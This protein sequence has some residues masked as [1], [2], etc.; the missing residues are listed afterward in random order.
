MANIA[1]VFPAFA[2][3]GAENVA[4]T[5]CDVLRSQYG[6]SI[7]IWAS[8]M[9]PG[10]KEALTARGYQ[11]E[12]FAEQFKARIHH[13]KTSRH[14]AELVCRHSIDV[15]IISVNAVG[16]ADELRR[17]ISPRCKIIFHLHGAPMWELQDALT[18]R[19]VPAGKP[20]K[21]LAAGLKYA[22]A[23]LKEGLF[24]TYSRRYLR[25]YRDMYDISDSYWV[26]C[27]GYAERLTELLGPGCDKGRIT[28]M[29]NP[30]DTRRFMPLAD[31]PK[32]KEVLFV[33]RLTYADKRVDR[34]LRVWATVGATRPDWTL[35]I[36]GD[37]KD[38]P[39]LEKLA[40]DL[41]LANVCF[42]G[43]GDPAPHYATASV[44]CLT[45]SFEG[46]PQVLVEGMAA[47]VVPVAFGC[48]D[49]VR[50]ILGGGRGAVVDCF[51]EHAY[52]DALGRLID[53]PEERQ[54]M[55][56]LYPAFVSQ[57]DT[58][59]TAAAWHSVISGLAAH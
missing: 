52:S 32:K 33:G 23:H 58:A 59:A 50:E 38:R 7:H 46:W 37:G 13:A 17:S 1:I 8:R 31:T 30:A 11:V 47:G 53:N 34:L 27:R 35:H 19:A 49:G 29:H 18:G 6:H 16:L 22:G 56:S 41:R 3:G 39:N 21:K 2:G 57:F 15:L 12:N 36:V 25:R 54:R 14:I 40:S 26:L 24:G 4:T 55:R 28:V 5:V 9:M 45:S 44:L 10:F 42:H 51:D 20:L 48:S 43:Y